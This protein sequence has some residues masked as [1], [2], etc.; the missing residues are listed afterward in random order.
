MNKISTLFA[1]SIVLSNPIAE[2]AKQISNE[3]APQK[4]VKSSNKERPKM[5]KVE[6]VFKGSHKAKKTSDF[7]MPIGRGDAK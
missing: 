2:E 5:P 3:D 4:T 7:T 1:I 6:D